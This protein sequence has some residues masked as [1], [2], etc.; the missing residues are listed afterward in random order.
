MPQLCQ[1]TQSM[2]HSCIHRCNATSCWLLNPESERLCLDMV[3][4]WRS[5]DSN[6]AVSAGARWWRSAACIQVSWYEPRIAGD[7]V[8]P[9]LSRKLIWKI[10]V[11]STEGSASLRLR[12]DSHDTAEILLVQGR[13]LRSSPSLFLSHTHTHSLS[14]LLRRPCELV[15][16]FSHHGSVC[17][18]IVYHLPDDKIMH[19]SVNVK[20][21]SINI[22]RVSASD[23]V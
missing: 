19:Q 1:M 6:E 21:V 11:L 22:L 12:A 23:S 9:A 8:P 4:L 13:R 2:P 10:A 17:E 16:Y 5:F 14:L 20:W 18:E 3:C 7:L 15:S